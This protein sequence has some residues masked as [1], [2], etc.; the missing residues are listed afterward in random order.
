MS[1]VGDLL[2]FVKRKGGVRGLA[3]PVGGVAAVMVV[4]RPYDVSGLA[5]VC[6][7]LVRAGWGG[8]VPSVQHRGRSSLGAEVWP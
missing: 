7:G 4:V 2:G 6:A 5:V 3:T 1:G 8:L